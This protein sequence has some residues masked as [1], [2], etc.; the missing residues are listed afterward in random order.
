MGCWNKTCGLTNIHIKGGADVYVFILEQL[1]DAHLHNKCYTT[2]F[3]KPL[4]LPFISKYDEYGGGSSSTGISFQLIMDALKDNLQ[5]I[6]LGDNKFHDIEVSKEKWSEDLFFEAVHEN[7]LQLT[8]GTNI[9]FVMFR[10]D[11]VDRILDEWHIDEYVG[12]GNG[13][14]GWDNAYI[15][16]TFKDIIDGIPAVISSISKNLKTATAL[17]KLISEH[18]EL[19]SISRSIIYDNDSVLFSEDTKTYTADFLRGY[20]SGQYRYSRIVN[21]PTQLCDFIIN[22]Q[23]SEA[24]EL[25][26]S[27]LTGITLD[28]FMHDVRKVWIPGAHEGSQSDDQTGYRLLIEAMNYVLDNEVD[29]DDEE[30]IDAQQH[31]HQSFIWKNIL[32]SKNLPTLGWSKYTFQQRAA[33]LGYYYFCWNDRVYYTTDGYDTGKIIDDI[34]E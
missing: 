30:V 8:S 2:S 12:D 18:P 5:E 3:Y 19:S 6:P 7:I 17:D 9:D 10:K 11:A 20:W 14:T 27:Y 22:N 16:Y 15:R 34:T 21:I 32:S 28:M 26:T 1:S 31:T 29:E 13:T 23:L 24:T 4:L 33:E 25:L